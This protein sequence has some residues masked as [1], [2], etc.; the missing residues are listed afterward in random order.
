MA[1]P[2]TNCGGGV[3]KG[4]PAASSARIEYLVEGGQLAE[5]QRYADFAEAKE[6][7][8]QANARVRTVR[9]NPA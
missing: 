1:G 5:P 8:R 2:C 7:S 4:R 9:V 3:R 6:A